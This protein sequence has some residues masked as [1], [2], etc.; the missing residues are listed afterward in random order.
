[1]NL[2]EL[3]VHIEGHVPPTLT[4]IDAR[5][6]PNTIHVSHA[7]VLDDE[8]LGVSRQFYKKTVENLERDPRACMLITS[9]LDYRSYV[10]QL[11]RVR[12]ETSGPVFEAMSAAVDALAAGTAMEQVFKVK[13]VD[14]F[15]V[16]SMRE[17]PGMTVP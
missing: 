8:L 17:S 13:A 4:T 3:R 15:R 14:V 7:A 5:G 2:S 1:V 6:V 12:V 11:V 16:T 9:H 10:L